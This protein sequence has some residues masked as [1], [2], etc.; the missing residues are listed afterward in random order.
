MRTVEELKKLKHED[1][2]APNK[3]LCYG[4]GGTFQGVAPYIMQCGINLVGILDANKSGSAEVCGKKMPYF[5]ISQAIE[6][7]GKDVKV[8]ITIANENVI[9]QVEQTLVQNGFD[10]N[11]IFDLN[12]WTWLTIPAEKSYCEYIGGYLQFMQPALSKCCNTGVVDAYLC[13]WFVEGR[14][15]EQSVSNFL[16]K[17]TYYMEEMEQGRIPLYCQ[18]CS[19]LSEHRQAAN[20]RINQFIISDHAVCNADCIDCGDACSVPKKHIGATVEERYDAIIKTLETLQKRDLVAPQA[21]F[22]IAGGEITINPYRKQLYDAV[23]RSPEMEIQ[24]LSN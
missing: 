8:V 12:V 15:L 3:V 23:R 11:T 14:P 4:G 16:E 10:V 2:M 17:R 13:E 1:F 24:F 22:Q 21:V 6:R 9:Q 18:N 20:N 7:F 5:S 19:Y